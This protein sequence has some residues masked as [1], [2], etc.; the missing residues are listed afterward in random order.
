MRFPRQ[1]ALNF[2]PITLYVMLLALALRALVPSGFMP[3]ASALRDGRLEMAFCSGS[4]VQTVVI[5]THHHDQ[6]APASGDM[7]HQQSQANDCPFSV[8]SALPAMPAMEDHLTN[9]GRMLL[10][11]PIYQSLVDDTDWGIPIAQR[12]YARAKIGY[13]PVTRASVERI[14]N[15]KP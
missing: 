12:I 4:G 3:D 13:H 11:S 15:K 7:P 10:I 8:L 1:R 5:D 6:G 9:I 14:L 2:R